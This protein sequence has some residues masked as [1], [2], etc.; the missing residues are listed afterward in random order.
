MDKVYCKGCEYYRPRTPTK[1]GVVFP[2]ECNA[3]NNI[4]DSHAYPKSRRTHTPEGRNWLNSCDW[5]KPKKPSIWKRWFA[6]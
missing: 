6:S 1:F 3:P 2:E 5:F 4:V